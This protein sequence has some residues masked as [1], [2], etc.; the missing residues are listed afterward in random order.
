MLTLLRHGRTEANHDGRLLG[1]LDLD[2][3]PVGEAQARAAAEAIRAA[4]PVD[5]VVASPL[6]R[7]MATAEALGLPVETDDRLMEVDY[8]IF[9]GVAMA[10]VP[11]VVWNAWLTDPHFV[12]EGGESFAALGERVR[13]A[14]ADLVSAACDGHVV[15]VSHVSPI[16]AMC[17]WALGIGDE[18]QWRF[19]VSQAS[20]SRIGFR[21]TTP[22]LV[23]FND[24]SH[25]PE[26]A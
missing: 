13:A 9:D 10:D 11:R 17:A 14:A 5:R 25:L 23:G 4:G 2:L 20:I 12:P 26:S 7:T 8:G 16:K 1:R 24:V 3:D 22:L 21:G 6:R 15:V 18:A 19:S